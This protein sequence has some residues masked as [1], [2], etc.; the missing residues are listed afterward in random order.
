[1]ERKLHY[2]DMYISSVEGENACMCFNEHLENGSAVFSAAAS[3]DG[4]M[5]AKLV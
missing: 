3:S 5:V 4:N 1:M 2:S